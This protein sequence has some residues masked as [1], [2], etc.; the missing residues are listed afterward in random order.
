MIVFKNKN[1]FFTFLWTVS[2]RTFN[3]E[4]VW[5]ATSPN[6]RPSRILQKSTE[7]SQILAKWW[8]NWTPT[9]S[10]KPLGFTHG[11]A[12]L[13]SICGPFMIFLGTMNE[14]GASCS[15]KSYFKCK[16]RKK[17]IRTKQDDWIRADG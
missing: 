11:I 16:Q 3:S 1:L 14:L 9:K 2:R 6:K 8:M 12:L 4:F 15:L 5:R 10:V 17:D 13:N 7:A